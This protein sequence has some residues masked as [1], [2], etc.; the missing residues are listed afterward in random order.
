MP[1][2]ILSLPVPPSKV[3]LPSLPLIVSLPAGRD[4]VVA[5]A[6]GDGVGA[7]VPVSTSLLARAW[8][9]SVWFSS[10]AP[11]SGELVEGCGRAWPS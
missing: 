6:A 4:P 9:E 8:V 2:L 1:P 3:S 5:E 10:A 7:L 11:M